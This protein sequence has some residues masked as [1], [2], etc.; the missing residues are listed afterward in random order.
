MTRRHGMNEDPDLPLERDVI[1]DL[2]V[3]DQADRVLAEAA[4]N[5]QKMP[6]YEYVKKV[7][8]RSDRNRNVV[9]AVVLLISI[10]ALVVGSIAYSDG[11]RN[12]TQISINETALDTYNEAIQEL[13]AKGVP[14]S[15]LP[16][17]PAQ[18]TGSAEVDVDGLIEATSAKVIA[19]IRNNPALTGPMGDRGPAGEPCDP[20][21]NPACV[22]PEGDEGQPGKP[23]TSGTPGTPGTPGSPGTPGG[24]GPKGDAGPKPVAASFDRDGA[25]SCRYITTYDD[26]S[27]LA[28]PAPDNMC[29]PAPIEEPTEGG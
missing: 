11:V 6:T 24:E 5:V 16:P 1:C 15:E 13:R 28:A 17:P 4:Q 23:G 3:L 10:I 25:G 12:A 7:E 14:E 19:N 20:A 2:S 9:I 8:R 27:T 21:I 26:G 18:P 22:G 29:S